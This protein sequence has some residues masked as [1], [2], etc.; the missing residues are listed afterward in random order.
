M[1]TQCEWLFYDCRITFW[2]K[3]VDWFRMYEVSRKGNFLQNF[4]T[5]LIISH[6]PFN[7]SRV[8]WFHMK[9]HHKT[10]QNF[11]SFFF[12]KKMFIRYKTSFFGQIDWFS[13]DFFWKSGQDGLGVIGSGLLKS[14]IYSLLNNEF[15]FVS[16]FMSLKSVL[17][18]ISGVQK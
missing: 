1:S 14:N 12:L 9:Q 4:H 15:F 17:N 8:L 7:I 16:G 18:E 2:I 3:N 6:E 10:F 13:H 5:F 11:F